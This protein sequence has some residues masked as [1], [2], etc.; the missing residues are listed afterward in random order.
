MHLLLTSHRFARDSFGGTEVLTAAIGTELARRGWRVSWLA[1]TDTPGTGEREAGVELWPIT[2]GFGAHYPVGWRGDE[3]RQAEKAGV[4]LRS[5]PKVDVVHVMHPA[6]VGLALTELEELAAVPLFATLTDY[7]AVCPD[8]QL[9]HRGTGT[10]CRVDAAASLCAGCCGA[11]PESASVAEDIAAYRQ[12]NIGFLNHRATAVFTMTPHQR[13]LLAEAGVDDGRFAGDRAVYPVPPSWSGR[14]VPPRR[15]GPFRFGFIGRLSPEKGLDVAAAALGALHAGS[16]CELHVWGAPDGDGASRLL[17]QPG[18]RLHD[19]LPLDDL[20]DAFDAID[21]LLVPSLWLENHPLVVTYAQVLGVPLIVSD[22]PSMRHLEGEGIHFAARGDVSAWIAAMQA[23]IET[24]A[25]APRSREAVA[26]QNALFAADID[27]LETAY[28]QAAASPAAG[29]GFAEF[30]IADDF[31]RYGLTPGR[32]AASPSF[33]QVELTDRCNLTC[34][35]CPRATVP[36]TLDVLDP[37]AF[38]RLLDSAPG[39]EHISFVGGGEAL[40]VNDFARYVRLCTERGIRTSTVSNGLLV[41]LRLR[42][43]IEAGLGRLGISVDSADDAEL[44]AIRGGMSLTALERSIRA[45]VTMT[46]GT[47]TAFFAATTLS[48]DNVAGFESIVRFVARLGVREMSVESLHHWGDDGTLNGRSLLSSPPALVIARIERGLAAARAEG[49]AVAI[50]DYTRLA[51]QERF[52][53]AHCPWP[54]DAAYVTS[55]GEVT[56]CCVHLTASDGNVLGSMRDTDF[57]SIWRGERYERFRESFHT[58]NEW[59]SCRDCVYRF[60]F[61][62]AVTPA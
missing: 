2:P 47:Q 3:A 4:W 8:F 22:V 14:A 13:L 38:E 18:L 27:R 5:H 51:S 7:T 43:A 28:L 24:H 62:K 56:P 15:E 60:E 25:P 52:R 23:A 29:D 40:F 46:A 45:A 19:P 32:P 35:S 50:F 59:A 12:R 20:V 1:A 37:A 44:R 55:R 33:L 26:R 21:C 36:S 61:G 10:I 54:W 34:A 58:E 30:R 16:G 31:E 39:A 17:A 48:A 53:D 57:A 6:R 42:A 49:I 41:P 11:D 9:F